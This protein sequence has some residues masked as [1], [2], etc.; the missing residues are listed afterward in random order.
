MSSF[1]EHTQSGRRDPSGGLFVLNVVR[2]H[3]VTH[4]DSSFVKK[5]TIK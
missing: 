4:Q 5:A 2:R 1:Q 3:H